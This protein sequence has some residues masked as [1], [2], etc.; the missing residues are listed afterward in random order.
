VS[1]RGDDHK[2]VADL[3]SNFP[4]IDSWVS[5]L[6]LL[7]EHRLRADYDNRS[8]TASENVLAPADCLAMAADFLKVAE[9][10]LQAEY[11]LKV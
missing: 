8:D 10:F 11:G 6:P 3:P 1:L 4:D 5:K 9:H 2:K 7:Y